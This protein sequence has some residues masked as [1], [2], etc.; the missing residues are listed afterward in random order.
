MIIQIT[1]RH[2]SVT[3]GMKRYAEQ[4]GEKLVRIFDGLTKIEI[5]LDG[6][7]TRQSAEAILAVA[8]GETIVVRAE[9]SKM[10]AAID[11]MIDRAERRVRDH[12]EKRRDHRT[13]SPEVSDAASDAGEDLETYSEVIDRTE[14]PSP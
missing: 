7:G 14:F 9:E 2:D 6:Q 3:D 12:K 4:K 5:V 11:A 1:A 8:G 13:E 10:N